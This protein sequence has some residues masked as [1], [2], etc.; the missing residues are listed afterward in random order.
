MRRRT[1]ISTFC[2]GHRPSH[3]NRNL[4][5]LLATFAMPTQ[6]LP[7]APKQG[8]QP[9]LF[10]M[11]DWPQTRGYCKQLLHWPYQQQPLLFASNFF[12]GQLTF[13]NAYSC[14]VLENISKGVQRT[15]PRTLQRTV[16]RTVQRTL[17]RTVPR[18][19]QGKQGRQQGGN[20]A[21]AGC[22]ALKI[23]NIKYQ[24]SNIKYKI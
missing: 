12:I 8:K 6:L 23:S 3:Y 5:Y 1:H 9:L 15:V 16:Q 22:V 4:G 11:P 14:L 17:P 18:T 21:V 7:A 19:K 2:L 24:I 13:C 20:R 10:P